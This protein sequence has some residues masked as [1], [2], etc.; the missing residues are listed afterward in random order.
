MDGRIGLNERKGKEKGEDLG[1]KAKNVFFRT[2]SRGCCRNR[3]K[4]KLANLSNGLLFLDYTRYLILFFS[5]SQTGCTCWRWLY[6]CINVSLMKFQVFYLPL[7]EVWSGR[8][9]MKRRW[10]RRKESKD[11]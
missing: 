3:G 4:F 5:S 9:V 1:G 8:V 10:S 6:A 11:A 7:P 2:S